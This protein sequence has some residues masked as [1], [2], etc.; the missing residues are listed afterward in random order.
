MENSSEFCECSK[1]KRSCFGVV[2]IGVGMDIASG[3][4]SFECSRSKM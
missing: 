2:L 3:F 1:A 4:W